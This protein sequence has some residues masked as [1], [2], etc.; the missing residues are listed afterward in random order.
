ME[1]TLFPLSALLQEIKVLVVAHN[2]P[3]R[4][5]PDWYVAIA[6]SPVTCPQG[7][8]QSQSTAEVVAECLTLLLKLAACIQSSEVN[9]KYLGYKKFT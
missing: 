5:F 4:L 1:F 7:S 2:I 3:A 8:T 9:F 6:M